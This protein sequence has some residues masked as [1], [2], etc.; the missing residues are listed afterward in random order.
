MPQFCVLV[1]FIKRCALH[2]K[3]AHCYQ[4]EGPGAPQTLKK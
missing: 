2:E 1:S 4:G 3:A